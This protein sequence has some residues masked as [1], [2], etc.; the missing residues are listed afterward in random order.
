LPPTSSTPTITT[1][2]LSYIGI[3]DIVTTLVVSF[4]V[5]TDIATPP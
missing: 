2:V 5:I 3:T 1:A 4:I